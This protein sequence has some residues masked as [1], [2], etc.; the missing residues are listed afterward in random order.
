[1]HHIIIGGGPAGLIAAETIRKL[2]PFDNISI[3]SDEPEPAYSRM[4]IPY[5]LM[6]KWTSTVRIYAKAPRMLLI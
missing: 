2:A 4:A 5:L 3:I 1:M 6:A